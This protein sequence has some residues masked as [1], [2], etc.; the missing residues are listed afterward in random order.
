M[1]C[2]ISTFASTFQPTHFACRTQRRTKA[3][4]LFIL[5]RDW[6]TIDAFTEHYGKDLEI[7]GALVSDTNHVHCLQSVQGFEQP[8]QPSTSTFPEIHDNGEKVIDDDE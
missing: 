7:F 5:Y 1:A 4:L 2:P 6:A 8:I 3:T